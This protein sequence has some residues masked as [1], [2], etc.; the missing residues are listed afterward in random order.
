VALTGGEVAACR[1]TKKLCS[2]LLQADGDIAQAI[3]WSLAGV[4]VRIGYNQLA[5]LLRQT[6]AA[7]GS[8]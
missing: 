1:N 6:L 4:D 2:I 5:Q 3:E 7:F 8:F